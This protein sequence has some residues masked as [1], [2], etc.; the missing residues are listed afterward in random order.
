M[1]R[2]ENS[3]HSNRF[4]N[5]SDVSPSDAAALPGPTGREGSRLEGSEAAEPLAEQPRSEVTGRHDAGSGANETVNM[6]VKRVLVAAFNRHR[7][8]CGCRCGAAASERGLS[9]SLAARGGSALVKRLVRSPDS[10]SVASSA[11][12][13]EPVQAL[14][15]YPDREAPAG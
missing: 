3:P 15:A 14:L 5:Q 12:R 2:P 1:D 13:A 6:S 4:A 8:D 10:F 7:A 11:S 9:L